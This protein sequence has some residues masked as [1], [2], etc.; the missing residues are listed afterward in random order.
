MDEELPLKNLDGKRL[1]YI[2]RG[3]LDFLNNL[4]KN[5]VVNSVEIDGETLRILE[6]DVHDGVG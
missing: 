1:P 6:D 2:C 5:L 4:A 3:E